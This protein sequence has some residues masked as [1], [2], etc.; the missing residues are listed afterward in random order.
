MAL[1][2]GIITRTLTVSTAVG[3]DKRKSSL[4][5]QIA[6]SKNIL[7]WSA[8]EEPLAKM[9]TTIRT[10]PDQ[11]AILEIP[12]TNQ[13]GFVDENLNA[14]TGWHYTITVRYL[15]DGR[16]IGQTVTKI[17]KPT[18][19]TAL[20]TD[21]DSIPTGDAP[22]YQGLPGPRGFSA[23]EIAVA[24]GFP[25]TEEQ[26]LA[27]LAT[28][29]VTPYYTH[30]QSTPSAEWV[31]VHNLGYYPGGVSI[32]DSSGRKVWAPYHYIDQNS[33]RVTMSAAMS[34]TAHLS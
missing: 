33:V 24:N 22:L 13:P 11:S 14:A 8:T 31:I 7:V 27:S 18:T 3:K 2:T 32:T 19:E 30:E 9:F 16:K 17:F 28:G 1:P 29:G 4:E 25:G 20:V 26:W 34:G 12:V 10:T 21:F 23:Y 6:P 5:I 15:F